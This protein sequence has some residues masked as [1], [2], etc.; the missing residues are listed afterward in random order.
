MAWMAAFALSLEWPALAQ[1]KTSV[2]PDVKQWQSP[3]AQVMAAYKTGDDAKGT[4]LAKHALELARKK[5]GTRD[6]RTLTRLDNLAA[7]YHSQGRYGEAEPLYRE[8]L[9]A[10]REVLWSR[11]PNT[12]NSLTNL[13]ALYQPGPLRRGGAA[14][15]GSAAGAARGAR[16]P[17]S[18][19]AE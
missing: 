4:A 19:D 16:A 12:L 2:G 6:P 15:S 5:F 14:P 18:A 3:N 9:Q 8:A 1:T 11:D 13:G 7:L 17:P 10:R